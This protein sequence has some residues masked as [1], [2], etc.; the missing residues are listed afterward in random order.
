MTDS[1]VPP[2]DP[3]GAPQQPYSPPAAP[4]APLTAADDKLWAS[5]AHFGGIIGPLPSL[6]IY[7]ILKDRGTLVRQEA[8]EALNFQIGATI[9]YIVLWIAGAI[10]GAIF[11]PLGIL[12]GFLQFALWAV[13][14]VFSIIGGVRVQQ[15]GAYRYPVTYRFIS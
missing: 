2:H 12:V 4:A 7:L 5:L 3:Q 13:V 6:L 10:L 1:A 9:A 14:V 8:K 15:G 11:W